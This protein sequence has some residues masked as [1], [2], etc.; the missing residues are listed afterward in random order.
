VIREIALEQ[1]RLRFAR[2]EDGHDPLLDAL[3]VKV[4]G[5]DLDPYQAADELLDALDGGAAGAVTAE[6]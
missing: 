6:R 2:L 3:A 4:A 1:V 5:R